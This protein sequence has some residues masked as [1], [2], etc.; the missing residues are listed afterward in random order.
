M[1]ANPTLPQVLVFCICCTTVCASHQ[2]LRLSTRTQCRLLHQSRLACVQHIKAKSGAQAPLRVVTS[3]QV[4]NTKT[5]QPCRPRALSTDAFPDDLERRDPNRR[6]PWA[7]AHLHT[8]SARVW[9]SGRQGR[10][11]DCTAYRAGRRGPRPRRSLIEIELG[12]TM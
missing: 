1:L 3:I 8:P 5:L 10:C 11:T 2:R 6:H 9:G 4:N 7:L 12:Y